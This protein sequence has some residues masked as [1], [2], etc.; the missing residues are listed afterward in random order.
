MQSEFGY[1]LDRKPTKSMI[2]PESYRSVYDRC[3]TY[4]QMR[5][6]MLPGSYQTQSYAYENTTH[7]RK[8]EIHQPFNPNVVDVE[9]HLT[10][11]ASP[12]IQSKYKPM[13][14]TDNNTPAID[15]PRVYNPFVSPI[16]HSNTPYY[17]D[18]GYKIGSRLNESFPVHK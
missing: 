2:T 5:E 15:G 13:C 9:N 18:P 7:L 11:R 14:S 12:Y 4:E 10:N 16:I 1:P 8:N 6:S 3:F 17:T